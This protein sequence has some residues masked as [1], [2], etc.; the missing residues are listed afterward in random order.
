MRWI[1]GFALLLVS[2]CTSPEQEFWGRVTALC[3]NA[4]AGSMTTDDPQD[5][6]FR[7]ADLAVSFDACSANRIDM[8]LVKDGEPYAK[9]VLTR[10]GD[11]LELRHIHKDGLTGYGGF[12]ADN[13]SGSRVN[14]PADDKTKAMFDEADHEAG[15]QNVWALSARSGSLFTYEL[16]RPERRVVFA[17]NTVNPVEFKLS[18]DQKAGFEKAE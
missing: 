11:T 13:S 17:F 18:P 15:K 4:Y 14:F 9:W 16:E 10:D 6:D 12:S 8:F 1:A 2:A 7:D 5:A 3:E